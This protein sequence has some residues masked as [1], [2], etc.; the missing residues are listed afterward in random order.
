MKNKGTKFKRVNLLLPSIDYASGCP[1]HARNQHPHRWL[2]ATR[3]WQ[4]IGTVTLNPERE[5]QEMKMAA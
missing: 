1:R 2:G 4:P 3:K 5:Q